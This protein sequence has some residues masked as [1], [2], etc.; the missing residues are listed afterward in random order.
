MVSAP[1]HLRPSTILKCE[2]NA[3]EAADVCAAAACEERVG[4]IC[5]A[6]CVARP[7]RNGA[8]A[9]VLVCAFAFC[10]RTHVVLRTSIIYDDRRPQL[11]RTRK[12]CTHS[13]T[14]RRARGAFGAEVCT[15]RTNVPADGYTRVHASR[16]VG[17]W[18]PNKLAS[19][20]SLR[21]AAAADAS[22]C[23]AIT[24]THTQYIHNTYICVLSTAI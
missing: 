11:E 18:F 16:A 2:Q 1:I 19:R 6:L 9:C 20:H 7:E 12:T 3:Y 15:Y 10:A 17:T 22:L 24:L 4:S 14:G 13:H 21:A 8:R 23:P 5:T